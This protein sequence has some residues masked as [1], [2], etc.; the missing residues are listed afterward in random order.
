MEA[1]HTV[2]WMLADVVILDQGQAAQIGRV[3][4]VD[5][6]HAAVYFPE[7]ESSMETVELTASMWE[8]MR[9]FRTDELAC[10]SDEA[11]RTPLLPTCSE[12]TPKRLRISGKVI[13]AAVTHDAVH[14]VVQ[15]GQSLFLYVLNV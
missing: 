15:P 7:E 3:L 10:V 13:G 11:L 5:G 14:C 12:D 2:D 6:P 1:G 4:K 9:L 8:S